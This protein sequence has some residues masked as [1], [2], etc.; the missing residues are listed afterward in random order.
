VRDPR[1]VLVLDG[2]QGSSLAIVR[3]LGRR[4]IEVDVGERRA[5]FLSS[6]SR[7]A[8]A[9]FAYPDPLTDPSSF[10]GAVR[11][12]TRSRAYDL[13]IPVTEDTV[14]PLAK[15]REEIERFA[16][17]AIA[18][19]EALEIMSDKAKTFSL[20]AALGVPA[21]KSWTFTT[22]GEVEEAAGALPLPIVVKPSRS[23]T[24]G[25]TARQ[26]LSVMYAHDARELIGLAKRSIDGVGSVILQEYFR[27]SG[28]GVELLADR[29]EIVYAF[30]HKRLHELPLTG[31]GSCLR[32][33]VPV[34]PTLLAAA[35]K[36]MR[37]VGWHGVAMVEL[38]LDEATGE[39]RL[40]EVNG[41][42]WG[43][44]PLA[45]AAGADFPYFLLE[46][47]TKG[48]RPDPIASQPK[49]GV[50]SRKLADDVYW[51]VQV[52]RPNQS[53]P[54]IAW[55]TR[56]RVLKDALLVLSWRH[57]FDVQ[58]V[59][60]PRPGIIDAVRTGEWF[61]DRAKSV[62]RSK[63]IEREQRRARSQG[64]T[65]RRLRKAKSILFVCYGNI[66]RSMLAERHLRSL[67]GGRIGIASAGFHPEAGRPADP[68]MVHEASR[69]GL[70][71]DATASRVL[72]GAMIDASDLV[73]V[74]EVKHLVRLFA[75]HPSSKGKAFLLRTVLMD[76]PQLEIADPYGGDE[77]AY[78]ACFDQ[79][80]ACTRAIA[81]T[82]ESTVDS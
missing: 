21:P 42:F 8:H 80:V 13:V 61:V 4:G 47:Y 17:L 37:A 43:S 55:P 52:L 39:H 3:S 14:Q 34:M 50:Y 28:V 58:S 57:H 27:G 6:Y 48:A 46:L 74:M 19:N 7:F 16:K 67:V 44:L 59:S 63:R 11:D 22:V 81:S 31:G 23:I 68:N 45:V 60:D 10:V 70:A 72:D 64:E 62:V 24:N 9:A 77:R 65:A 79:V 25:E 30:Q 1:R 20:A 53:E 76:G 51:H 38:K 41:R 18:P 56:G 32:V 71:I 12:R 66:N 2:N 78:A 49:P 54:L 5:P 69:K 26:K 36:L 82:I 15:S 29:G 33:S 35:E 75:E 73:L 40:M